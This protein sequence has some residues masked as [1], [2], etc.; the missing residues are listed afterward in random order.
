MSYW[1]GPDPARTHA[2]S[3]LAVASL[4]C[5]I[6]AWLTCGLTGP[7]A[8][9]LGIFALV[10]TKNGQRPGHGLAWGGVILGG[11]TTILWILFWGLGLTGSIFSAIGIA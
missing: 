6:F 10:Q 11:M 9:V 1:A 7:V 5:G 2:T 4:I 3:G 8:L